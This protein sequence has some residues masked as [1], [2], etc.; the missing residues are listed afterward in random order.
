MSRVFAIIG[1]LLFVGSLVFFGVCFGWRFAGGGVWTASEG[2]RPAAIDFGLFTLF[3]LHHSIFA[4]TGL[5]AWIERVFPP[6]LERSIYVWVASLLFL[7]VCAAW[8]PVPGTLWHVAGWPR[9][10]F[11][12]L[13]LAGAALAIIAA[14]QLDTLT[15]AGVRQVFRSG[16]AYLAPI[17]NS[18]P[19]IALDR[20]PYALVR[21]PIYLGWFAMVWFTPAMNGTRLV[22]AAVSCLYLVIAMPFEER[23]LRRTLGDAYPKYAARVRWKLLPGL[24]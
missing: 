20:G 4:R 2:V 11:W 21:H 1:G 22:F 23:D 15:L 19:P 3:A 24:Y 6:E 9:L 13:Q 12:A 7:I 18:Q 8:Q 10:L 14:R 5:R 16:E 17:N